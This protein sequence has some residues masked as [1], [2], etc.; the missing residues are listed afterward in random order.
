MLLKNLTEPI[1]FIKFPILLL[2]SSSPRTRMVSY[3]SGELVLPTTATRIIMAKS[4]NLPTYQPNLNSALSRA[5]L[6]FEAL[7]RIH[8]SHASESILLS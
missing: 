7:S 4:Q 5:K 6:H 3:K 8:P 2:T 1:Y